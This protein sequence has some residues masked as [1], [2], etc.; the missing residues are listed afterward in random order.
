VARVTDAYV[1]R[2]GSNL[3]GAS[4]ALFEE[5]LAVERAIFVS[6]GGFASAE[7][8]CSPEGPDNVGLAERRAENVVKA[9][10]K[11]FGKHLAV[12]LESFGR[13]DQLAVLSGMLRPDAL[14]DP[15]KAD[16]YREQEASEFKE[17][18][19]V[20]LLVE[21]TVFLEI[22]IEKVGIAD[23]TAK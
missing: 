3:G 20:Q 9:I 15:A 14:N 16:Q 18:R 12:T 8:H 19:L 13:S 1:R 11:A 21:G 6:G 23:A 4:L 22:K 10:E 17:F 5:F 2:G 7:G